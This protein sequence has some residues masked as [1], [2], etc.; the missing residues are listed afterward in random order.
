M[1]ARLILSL[2]LAAFALPAMAIV[3]CHDDTAPAMVMAMP[4]SGHHSA[5]M[6]PAMPDD[7]AMVHAC[8]G[9]IPPSTLKAG[10]AVTPLAKTAEI[11]IAGTMSFDPGKAPAPDTPPP[12]AEA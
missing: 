12:R 7:R 8:I 3:P 10:T 11:R 9:C 5:P 1:F 2:L 4:A 6:A